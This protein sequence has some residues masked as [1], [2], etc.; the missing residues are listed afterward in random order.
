MTYNMPWVR[1]H[2]KVKYSVDH[3]FLGNCRMPLKSVN[4]RFSMM[5]EYK[6]IGFDNVDIKDGCQT[7]S[8]AR[9]T[10]KMNRNRLIF[11]S[12]SISMMALFNSDIYFGDS[13]IQDGR[14]T[15]S[16][17]RLTRKMNRND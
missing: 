1:G 9:L 11:Q 13:E 10:R 17:A 12:C 3:G 15:G 4:Q 7:G 8:D 14:Q 2:L 5:E 16:A 6:G